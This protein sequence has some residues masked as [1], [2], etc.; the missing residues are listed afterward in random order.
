MDN[1][2]PDSLATGSGSFMFQNERLAQNQSQ[3][4]S[5]DA[6]RKRQ[7]SELQQTGRD[8]LHFL[9]NARTESSSVESYL[10]NI[11]AQAGRPKIDAKQI[12]IEFRARELNLILINRLESWILRRMKRHQ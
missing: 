10:Q 9:A 2:D 7:E 1:T 12:E 5:A 6:E 3:V 8:L 11:Y 4:V